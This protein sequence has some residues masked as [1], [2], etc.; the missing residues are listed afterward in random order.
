MRDERG[1]F[2]QGCTPQET[3]A[4]TPPPHPNIT[5]CITQHQLVFGKCTIPR[6]SLY[7]IMKCSVILDFL[8]SLQ[9]TDTKRKISIGN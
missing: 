4:T 1:Y 5:E 9:V 3:T 2:P 7:H 6:C 8:N